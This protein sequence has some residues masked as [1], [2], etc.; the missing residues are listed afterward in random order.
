M[1]AGGT[2]H[3]GMLDVQP[4]SSAGASD[5]LTILSSSAGVKVW[6][7]ADFEGSLVAATATAALLPPLLLAWTVLPGLIPSILLIGKKKHHGK[8]KRMPK[9]S[10]HGALP[11]S[12]VMRRRRAAALGRNKHNHH[13]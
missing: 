13:R 9:K 3:K 6:G 10:N 7:R 1:G 2:S 5:C 8:N 11:C 4:R 12:H